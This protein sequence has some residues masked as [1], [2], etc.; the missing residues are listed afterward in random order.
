MNESLVSIILPVHNARYH[1]EKTIQSVLSQSYRNFELILIDDGSTD[2]SG[3]VCDRAVK[4]D[5]RVM[6][7]HQKNMGISNARNRGLN[8]S[9]G[10]YIVFCDHDDLMM[11][12]CLKNAVYAVEKHSVGLVKFTYRKESFSREK[13]LLYFEEKVLPKKIFLLSELI[14]EYDVFNAVVRAIWNGMYL[15]EIICE[16]RIFFDETILYGME[17]F[18][19]NLDY[20]QHVKRVETISDRGY[21]HF[22]WHGYSTSEMFHREKMYDYVT[23][24][25]AEK[26]LLQK[27]AN[28]PTSVWIR[29]QIVYLDRIIPRLYEPECDMTLWERYVYLRRLN[30]SEK[31]KLNCKRH[32]CSDLK[33][34][35]KRRTKIYYVLF[36]LKLYWLL[37][38]WLQFLKTKSK[39]WKR[40]KGSVN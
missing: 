30:T 37:I 16:N 8:V 6:V 2:G 34:I 19:F 27:Y 1:I 22:M 39:M 31:L 24:A 4:S 3:Q 35:H 32:I 18:V 25:Q 26:Q 11:P 36:N 17:D 12:D 38:F 14:Q 40:F 15:R 5:H 10:K 13:E 7:L 33:F 23:A 29:H 21:L 9:K 20:L 28:L